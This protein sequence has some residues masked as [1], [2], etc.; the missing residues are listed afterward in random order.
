MATII[1]QEC[2]NCGA[3]EPECPNTAIYQGGVE[4]EHEGKK[5]A[6]LESD[7]FYIVPEKCTECVGFYDYEACAAVCPVD[8]CVTDPARPESEDILLLR[9]KAL[10]PEKEFPSQFPSRFHPRA[11]G[12][13]TAPAPATPSAEAKSPDAT[14]PVVQAKPTS[15][16]APAAAAKAAAVPKPATDKKPAAASKAQ[17]PA[18][19][20]APSGA[21]RSTPASRVARVERAVARPTRPLAAG[22]PAQP[23]AGELPSAFDEILTRARTPRVTRTSRLLGAALLFAAPILGALP[24]STKK[25]LEVAAGP[26]SW[27]SAQMCTALNVVHNFLLYP[28]FFYVV[29]L[30][31]GL[32]P[33]TE[34]DKSWIVVG[35]LLATVETLA[36][37]RDGIF[38]QLPASKMR[39]GPSLY[40]V[41]LGVAMHPLLARLTRSSTSGHVPV[42][43]FYGKEFEAKRERER[44]YGEVYFVEEFDRGYYVRLEMPRT[45]PPSAAR[46]ELSMGDVMP[47][48][49]ISVSVDRD[50][51]TIRGSVVDPALRAVCGISPAFPADFRTQIPLRGPLDGFRQQYA[52]KVLELAVLKAEV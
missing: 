2:I 16:P 14:K 4:F 51:V 1:T 8:C 38:R 32:Q 45:I 39:F 21:G 35:V 6:A 3:C 25:V 43:G 27:F 22:K 24:H 46:E 15:T 50:T 48:Y 10:H 29:G 42:E 41:P 9:A 40:G 17:A 26:G 5:S 37:L 33:F 7:I 12:T 44:R 31:T 30:L 11:A 52:D 49:D 23:Q 47:D 18:S 36:R 13:E 20:A 34:A 28:L 19:P